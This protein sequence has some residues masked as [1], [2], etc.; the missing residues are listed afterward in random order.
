MKQAM[1]IDFAMYRT[2]Q[3]TAAEPL[4]N[5]MHQ[6][7]DELSVAILELIQRL[8]ENNPVG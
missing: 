1:V 4:S 3:K 7:I 8:R 5:L 6:Q 2:Q